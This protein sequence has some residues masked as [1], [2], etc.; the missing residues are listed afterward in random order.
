MMSWFRRS[1]QEYRVMYMERKMPY[2]CRVPLRWPDSFAELLRKIHAV[3]GDVADGIF[4]QDASCRTQGES[5]QETY[6]YISCEESFQAII[7]RRHESNGSKVAYALITLPVAAPPRLNP[8][9]PPRTL[10]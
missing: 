1:P 8:P 5:D 9:G 3:T 7:P 4:V 6:L 2:P 10:Q